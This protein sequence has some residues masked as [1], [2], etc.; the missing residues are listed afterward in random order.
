M[1]YMEIRR[2]KRGY[3]MSPVDREERI[4]LFFPSIQ[5]L[6]KYTRRDAQRLWKKI[7]ESDGVLRIMMKVYLPNLPPH[8]EQRKPGGPKKNINKYF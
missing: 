7:H 6:A 3:M 4:N 8:A 1:R 5:A 2:T